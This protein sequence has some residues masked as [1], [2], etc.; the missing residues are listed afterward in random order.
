MTSWYPYYQNWNPPIFHELLQHLYSNSY[1]LR[2]GGLEIEPLVATP[3]HKPTI[4]TGWWFQLHWKILANWDDSSQY[5]NIWEKTCSSHHQ[6]ESFL[7]IFSCRFHSDN[8]EAPCSKIFTFSLI[9]SG[10]FFDSSCCFHPP[11][12]TRTVCAVPSSA[13]TSSQ[14]AAAKGLRC[15]KLLCPGYWSRH[16]PMG[17]VH[18]SHSSEFSLKGY[19]ELVSSII[20]I[21]YL[22]S[23]DKSFSSIHGVCK[24]DQISNSTNNHIYE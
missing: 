8:N 16:V 14:A 18:P 3:H 5:I 7:L 11:L 9:P 1:Q 21:G 4:I 20:I 24:L 15:A 6:P 23:S 12:G 13:F 22:K 2:S 19:L 10:F 17:Y